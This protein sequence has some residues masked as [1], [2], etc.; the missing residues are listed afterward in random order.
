LL[1]HQAD[2][3]VLDALA[4]ARCVPECDAHCCFPSLVL[5]AA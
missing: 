2:D 1:E 3:V 4:E 5:C